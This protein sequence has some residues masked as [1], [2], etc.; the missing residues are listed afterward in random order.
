MGR[1][2]LAEILVPPA[3]GARGYLVGTGKAEFQNGPIISLSRKNELLI[4]E[5]IVNQRPIATFRAAS[6]YRA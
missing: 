6:L 2:Y 5:E 1:A 3:A 4:L